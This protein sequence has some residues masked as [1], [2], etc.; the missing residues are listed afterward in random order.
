MDRHKTQR[1]GPENVAKCDHEFKNLLEENARDAYTRQWHR[2]E[3]GLRLNRF[4]IFINDIAGQFNMTEDEKEGLFKFLKTS[5]DNKLLNTLKVVIYNQETQRITMIKGLEIKR[6]DNGVLVFN[7][8][9]K[10]S[11]SDTTRKK[12]M[13]GKEDDFEIKIESTESVESVEDIEFGTIEE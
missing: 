11:K 2:I 10:K 3:R 8:N 1:K 5:L 12:K 4:R 7:L 6:G 9:I 13:G